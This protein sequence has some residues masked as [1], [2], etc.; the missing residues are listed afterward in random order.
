LLP[1]VQLAD[2]CVLVLHFGLNGL[3]TSSYM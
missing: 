2:E 1:R 3:H